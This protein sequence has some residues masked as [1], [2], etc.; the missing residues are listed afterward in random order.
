MI[1]AGLASKAE[2]LSDS[3]ELSENSSCNPPCSFWCD[4]VPQSARDSYKKFVKSLSQ[5]DESSRKFATESSKQLFNKPLYRRSFSANDC[6]KKSENLP[7]TQL[8]FDDESRERLLLLRRDPVSYF[9]L[10]SSGHPLNRSNSL[11]SALKEDFWNSQVNEIQYNSRLKDRSSMWGPFDGADSL[12]QPL[13]DC[14]PI[15]ENHS[16]SNRKGK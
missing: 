10:D 4:S 2:L 7:H 14:V 13:P 5:S 3:E 15:N 11:S 1:E 6:I 9:K 8:C 12:W 16:K